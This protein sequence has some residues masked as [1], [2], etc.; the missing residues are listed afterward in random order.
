MI[1]VPEWI[2]TIKKNAIS[3]PQI[4]IRKAQIKSLP[5][6]VW[7]GNQCPFYENKQCSQHW[8]I[9]FCLNVNCLL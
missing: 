3:K 4:Q 2:E 6:T 9:I 8:S 7:C 1:A 5:T